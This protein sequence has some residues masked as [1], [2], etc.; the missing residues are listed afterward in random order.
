MTAREQGI[1]SDVPMGDYIH[2]KISP[3]PSLSTGV[4]TALIERSPL[5]AHHLHPR[6]GKAGNEA[7]TRGEIG[8]AVHAL[9]LGGAPIQYV[10][11]VVRKSGPE[12]GQPFEPTDWMTSDAKEQRDAIRAAGGIP[13]LLNQRTLVETVAGQAKELLERRF[14]A[15]RTEQTMLWHKG[16]VWRRGRSDWLSDCGGFDVDLKT[17]DNAEQLAWIKSTLFS[18][19][20][21]IQGALRVDGHE[22]LGGRTRD[23]VFLLVELEAPYATSLVALS[24]NAVESAR[25]DIEHA[26]RKW[27]RCLDSGVWPGYGDEIVYA[28]PPP[29]REW[30]RETRGVA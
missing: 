13:L 9:V 29:W 26:A 6:L 17:C 2:D 11:S 24:T 30:D 5:H 28:E 19:G 3:E 18:G 12:K 1:F 20:Y 21:D 7:T 8:S 4:V 10:S 15:G 22:V 16:D 27:R 25:R 23:I 14:G